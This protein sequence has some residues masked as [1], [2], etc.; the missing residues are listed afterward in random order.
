MLAKLCC[1]TI[2]AFD[3][4]IL[5]SLPLWCRNISIFCSILQDE[6][7]GFPTISRIG[8]KPSTSKQ[9]V[10]MRQKPSISADTSGLFLWLSHFFAFLLSYYYNLIILGSCKYCS[11]YLFKR[12]S[13]LVFQ[14]LVEKF[15]LTEVTNANQRYFMVWNGIQATFLI[16]IRFITVLLLKL[17][18]VKCQYNAN[19]HLLLVTIK[20]QVSSMLTLIFA[21]L[22]NKLQYYL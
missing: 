5:L 21:S 10:T 9:A 8:S 1:S 12:N 2:F 18:N 15:L 4:K 3:H 17:R 16:M 14:F 11:E 20:S 7:Y 22:Y 6:T 19:K 13:I